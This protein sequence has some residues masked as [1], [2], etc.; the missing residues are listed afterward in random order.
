[1]GDDVT[2]CSKRCNRERKRVQKNEKKQAGVQQTGSAKVAV[3]V[4]KGQK[5]C[6]CSRSTDLLIRCTITKETKWIMVCGKCWNLPTV[7][8]GV[9]EGDHTNPHYRYGGLWK[10]RH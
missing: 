5:S 9:V 6:D 8:N 3:G 1:M 7:A 4:K 10:N 2:T